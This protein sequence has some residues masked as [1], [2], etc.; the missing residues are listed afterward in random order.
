M[1]VVVQKCSWG[2]DPASK[3]LSPN[4]RADTESSVAFEVGVKGHSDSHITG[5][6]VPYMAQPS[7]PT[8]CIYY[9]LSIRAVQFLCTGKRTQLV[10][11]VRNQQVELPLLWR[12][13]VSLGGS[14]AVT[15][16]DL[17]PTVA[18]HILG[19]PATNLVSFMAAKPLQGLIDLYQ[20]LE[21]L[22]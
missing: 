13:V 16:L 19:V 21:T 1:Q 3:C 20:W 4:F 14:Q 12:L 9:W 17:W 5:P 22:H 7:C 10:L 11:P 2:R 6:R 15:G 18:E 8:P